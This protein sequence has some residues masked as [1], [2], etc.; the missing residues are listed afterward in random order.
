MPKSDIEKRA[1]K[2]KF[3]VR[4]NEDG[5][6]KLIGTPI[7]Y[8]KISE[9]L[10]W[11]REKIAIGAAKEA[12]EKSDVRL[13]YGHNMD[14][15]LPLGRTS[16]GT[17]RAKETINGV[18]IE[19][20]PP[21]TQFARDLILAIERGDVQDMSFGFRVSDDDWSLADGEELRTIKKIDEIFDFSYVAFPAY[22]D[23]SAATRSF[24]LYK[25]A[26][27]GDITTEDENLEIELL[28]LRAGRI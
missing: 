18:E 14:S 20:D 24:N 5:S 15:I 6:K 8:D 16:A 25:T 27:K 23:T 10:G 7:V 12:L 28:S 3:E 11:F 22:T 21:D 17:L 4:E 26:G 1:M 19:A 2:V 13:L 9:N